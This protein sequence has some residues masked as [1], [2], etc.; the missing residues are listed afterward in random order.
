MTVK[1]NCCILYE[2][3]Y[4][5][6]FIV[7][8]L[9]TCAKWFLFGTLHFWVLVFRVVEA[10]LKCNK[11]L[12]TP[13]I[14]TRSALT[15]CSSCFNYNFNP[16][17]V[18]MKVFCFSNSINFP[19]YLQWYSFWTIFLKSICA[20]KLLVQQ[21]SQYQSIPNTSSWRLMVRH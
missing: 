12:T 18:L 14:F 17:I 19:W 21:F 7:R 15:N 1:C 4:F 13:W 2:L 20:I 5:D 16:T 8:E 6:I 3:F 9:W 10:T 11:F